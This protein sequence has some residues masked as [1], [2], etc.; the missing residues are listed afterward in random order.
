MPSL[1]AATALNQPAVAVNAGA[2]TPGCCM[3][4]E[5]RDDLVVQSADGTEDTDTWSSPANVFVKERT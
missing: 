1:Q 3:A 5:H 2:N 4:I